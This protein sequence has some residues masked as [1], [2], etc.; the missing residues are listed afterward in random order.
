MR[1]TDGFT[2]IELLVGIVCSALVTGA[3]ITFLLMGMNTTRSVLDANAD[4]RNAKIVITMMENLASEGSIGAVE[5]IGD[6]SNA[7]WTIYD[8]PIGSGSPILSYSAASQSLRG[9][10]GS[11]L[12]EG[13]L[14]SS[15]TVDD[16]QP[17]LLT[18]K[19]R[20]KASEYESSVYCRL[21]SLGQ[22][23][24]TEINI[25]VQT[26]KSFPIGIAS[27]DNRIR[28]L[29]T[30]ADQYGSTGQIEGDTKTYTLWYCEKETGSNGYI[31]GW[32]PDTPWCATFVSWAIDKNSAYLKYN[33][34][35]IP[36][37]ANVDTLFTKVQRASSAPDYNVLPGDLVFFDWD[38][39]SKV[40]SPDL[41]HV[42]V[43]L[44][45]DKDNEWIYTIEGNSGG[46]VAL[47]RYSTNDPS[48]FDYGILQWKESTPS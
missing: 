10:N 42:G 36:R 12:M 45:E 5:Q 41:E 34:E 8:G 31:N 43:L 6:A 30:L 28:F 33:H 7:D 3:I 15:L 27:K 20:T 37:E 48:I 47:R 26:E 46:R 2:L 44:Y 38:Y 21:L 4:Q 17:N 9:R 40:N 19:I 11:V 25:D 23:T 24:K 39:N 14:G 29:K 32:G 13:I 1:K 18:F 35:S 22:P 16:E